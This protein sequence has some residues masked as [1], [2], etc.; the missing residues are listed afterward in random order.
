MAAL[1]SIAV[2]LF[3]L[4]CY[5]E[6]RAFTTLILFAVWFLVAIKYFKKY[7]ADNDKKSENNT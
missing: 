4:Y 7:K 6:R 3:N 2:S 1:I 5:I